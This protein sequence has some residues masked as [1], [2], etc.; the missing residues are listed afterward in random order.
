MSDFRIGQ[1]VVCVNAKPRPGTG[2]IFWGP[3]VVGAIYT[4]AGHCVSRWGDVCI[5]LSEMDGQYRAVRFRPVVE[6]KTDIG[7]FTRMLTD[8]RTKIPV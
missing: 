7:I 6:R 4:V 8:N 3:P 5:T 1:K 2:W